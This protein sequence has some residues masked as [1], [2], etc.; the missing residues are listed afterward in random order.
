MNS[1][2]AKVTLDAILDQSLAQVRDQR[3]E[4]GP[5]TLKLAAETASI[6]AEQFP[7]DQQALAGRVT[8]CVA[9]LLDAAAQQLDGD[10]HEALCGLSDIIAL[11]AEQVVREAEAGTSWP[12]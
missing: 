8:M 6:I 7:G 4:A 2:I 1:P 9:Q 10:A 11:A 12:T 3:A 5:H